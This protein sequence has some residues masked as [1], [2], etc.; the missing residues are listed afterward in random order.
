M[1]LDYQRDH[2]GCRELLDRVQEL[3]NVQ[4]NYP[5]HMDLKLHVF[6]HIHEC[7]GQAESGGF[8]QPTFANASLLRPDGTLGKPLVI[9]V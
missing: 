3:Q 2:Y 7:G 6:G 9:E 8:G 1:N 5:H 4:T